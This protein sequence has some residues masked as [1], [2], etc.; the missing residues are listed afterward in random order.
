VVTVVSKISFRV[1]RIGLACTVI[2]ILAITFAFNLGFF[3]DSERSP[4]DNESA[5]DDVR[6]QHL[7]YF[8]TDGEALPYALFVP[9]TYNPDVPS[10]LMVSLHG[11]TRTYDWL[12]GYEGFL[13]LAEREGVIVVTPLGYTRSA[14]Y[15]AKKEHPYARQSEQ[16]VMQVLSL[17]RDNYNVDANRI[18][19]WGHSMGGGGTY[20][21]AAK[22]PDIWAALG[23][24]AP[25]PQSKDNPELLKKFSHLPIVVLQGDQDGLVEST[26]VWVEDMKELGM[27]HEYIEIPG[28]D[29]S[30]VISENR[31]NMARV[32]EYMVQ[33]KKDGA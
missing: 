11:L 10:P 4:K 24:A 22:Y 33:F 17:V 30:L 15:G 28:G 7:S 19:L 26:R 32:F 3:M 29:H 18:Y 12:M 6:I 14:W 1:K 16:D 5:I 31:N 20:H 8:F 9:S 21:L 27:Q 13:D 25:A 23:V 2:V